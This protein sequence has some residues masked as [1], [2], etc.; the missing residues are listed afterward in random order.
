MAV[1]IFAEVCS[2]RKRARVA[3]H[4]VYQPHPPSLDLFAS[5]VGIRN[6]FGNK[7]GVLLACLGGK[8]AG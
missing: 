1:S 7:I 6:K 2:N 4:N 3:G 5:R 8:G